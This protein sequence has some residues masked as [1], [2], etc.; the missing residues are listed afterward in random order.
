MS[1]KGDPKSF[2]IIFPDFQF[3]EEMCWDLLEM[4]FNV[5]KKAEIEDLV[6][7]RRAWIQL[8]GLPAI[9]YTESFLSKLLGKW[10]NL[11]S[12]DLS[13]FRNDELIAPFIQLST[14]A[15]EEIRDTVE[16]MILGKKLVVQI[17]ELSLGVAAMGAD[18]LAKSSPNLGDS[19]SSGE[20]DHKYDGYS[21]HSC[22]SDIPSMNSNDQMDDVHNERPISMHVSI[23]S[24]EDDT[25]NYIDPV[26]E[27][28]KFRQERL[29]DGNISA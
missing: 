2:L 8:R 14:S 7:P 13:V 28:L 18:R 19:Q 25:V 17:N 12:T 27:E 24:S 22:K 21:T 20:D 10:G 16:V 1:K 4:N 9:A 3:R 15:V 6:P 11:V 5:I 26:E 23:V 29:R